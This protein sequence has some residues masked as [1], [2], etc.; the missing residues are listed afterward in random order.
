[1]TDSEE[2]MV[3]CDSSTKII[4]A[5]NA[6]MPKLAADVRMRLIY[7]QR[8]YIQFY[9]IDGLYER[10]NNR[11]V[12]RIFDEFDSSLYIEPTMTGEVDG[13]KYRVYDAPKPRGDANHERMP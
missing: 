2:L 4:E 8:R 12:Q 5:M 7:I 6:V 13:M 9:G 3:S 11:T 1:M 10:V